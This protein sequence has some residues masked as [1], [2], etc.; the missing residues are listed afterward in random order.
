MKKYPEYKDSGVEWL[1]D[2]P[3]TWTLKPLKHISQFIVSN[4][5]KK[6]NDDEII[7]RLCN[8]SDVYNNDEISNDL[9]FMKGSVKP[10]EFEKFKLQEGDVIITKDSETPDDIAIP[11]YVPVNYDDIICGYHLAIIRN[12]GSMIGKYVYYLFKSY[13]FNQQFTVSARGITRFGLSQSAIANSII[14]IPSTLEQTAIANFLDHKT[15]QIDD[16]IERKKRLIEL[17]KEERTAVINQA[18]TKGLD[19]NVPMKDSGIEWLGEIPEHWEETKLKW[20]VLKIGS[21]ITPRGGSTV[22][23][24]EGIPLIR[25]QNVK[26]EG[27]DLKDVAYISNEINDTMKNSEVTMGDVLLN[28]T[29]ASIGRSCVYNESFVSNVNQHVCIIRST[30]KLECSFLNFVLQSS[31]GQNLIRYYVTGSG[32]KGLNFE[33]ISNFKLWLPDYNEQER[34]VEYIDIEH[35][36]IESQVKNI[37]LQINFLQEYKFSLIN[38]AVTGKIDVRKN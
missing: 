34:I 16:L 15:Q 2:I 21:G 9:D 33:N 18:V 31:Y 30:E 36:K 11:A 7:V 32:R 14:G 19:P 28:I 38:E 10:S 5:D 3:A 12:N 22:Y 20:C 35:N 29:G 37:K 17:L 25:S 4:V 24:N 27:L 6:L 13:R 26:F 1:G 23:K 8:Y